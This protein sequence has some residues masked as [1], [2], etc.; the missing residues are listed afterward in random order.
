MRKSLLILIFIFI[1][2]L[3]IFSQKEI[4]LKEAKDFSFELLKSQ[5]QGFQAVQKTGH[6]NITPE[7]TKSGTFS[8]IRTNKLMK[9]F[10]KGYPDLP[11]VSK[12]IEIPVGADIN[13]KVISYDLEI[14]NLNKRGIKNKLAPAQP[15]QEKSGGQK[16]D[17]FYINQKIYNTNEFIGEELVKVEDRGIMRNKRF[18]RLQISPL[19]YNPVANKLKVYNNIKIDVQFKNSDEKKADQLNKQYTSPYFENIHKKAVNYQDNKEKEVIDNSPITYVIISDPMFKTQLQ[20]FIK[21]KERKGFNVITAYTDEIG[22]TTS[23]IKSYL[24]D[25]YY[26]PDPTPPSFV[27]FVGDVDQVPAWEG[28]A[29]NHVTD[30]YYCEYT[31]DTLPDVYYGRFSAQSEAQLQTQIDKTLEYEKYEMAHPEYLSEALLVAGNDKEWEDIYGNGAMWYAD[32]Y[33]FNSNNDI[34]SHLFLQD[35]PNGNAAVHDSIIKNINAGV[36]YANYTAHCSSS[37]WAEPSF[38]N[39]DIST[40]TNEGKYGLWVGNCC[41]SLKFDD[42]ECFGEAALRAENKGA[43]GYIGGSN[44]TYWY[45]DYWWGVGNIASPVEQPSYNETG[46]GMYDGMFHT[47][48]NE[49]DDPS[50]WYTTQA[51]AITCGNLAVDASTSNKKEYY[52]EI[53]HLMGD[54][55]LMPYLGPPESISISI[56]PSELLIGTDSLTINTA[57]YAYVALSFQGNLLDA[58]QTGENGEATLSFNP[59]Q[60][61]GKVSLV[62]TAQNKQLYTDSIPIGRPATPYIVPDSYSITDTSGN[63]N[64]SIDFGEIISL[65]VT[66]KNLSDSAK[67]ISISDSLSEKDSYIS[68]IDSTQEYGN[69]EASGDSLIKGAFSFRVSDSVA[70][71]H[72]A[73]F[74]M[75]ISGKDTSGLEY[76]WQSIFNITINAPKLEIENLA[77]DDKSTGDGDS[78][79]DPGEKA[80]LLVTVQNT[81]SSKIY[82]IKGNLKSQ[83]SDITI[84]QGVDSSDNLSANSEVTFIF[85]VQAS[86]STFVGSKVNLQIEVSGGTNG[87]YKAS[88]TQQL[89]IGN[90]ATCLINEDDTVNTCGAYF[91]DSGADT[92]DYSNSES[93]TITFY[94]GISGKYIQAIFK[95]FNVEANNYE[96]GCY[97]KLYI[98]DGPDTDAELIGT[99]CNNNPPDTIIANN[100]TGALTFQF[101]SDGSLTKSGWKT[102]ITCIEKNKVTFSVNDGKNPLE[103][104][105]I[106]CDGYDLSTNN[107]GQASLFL[108]NDSYKYT[109]SKPGYTKITDTIKVNSDTTIHVNLT[110][111]IYNVEFDVY[112]SGDT[113]NFIEGKV[114]FNDTT[115]N[116]INGTCL[117]QNIDS[118]EYI[119]YQVDARGY[120]SITDSIIVTKDTTIDIGLK[121]KRFDV[122]IYTESESGNALSGVNVKVEDFKEK[123]D[124]GGY[125]SFIGMPGGKRTCYAE[126]DGY[127]NS[128]KEIFIYKDSTYKIVLSTLTDLDEETD[129]T[130]KIYPNPAA[131]IL[132]I[133]KTIKKPIHY[134]IIDL[135]GKTLQTGMLSSPLNKIKVSSWQPGIYFIRFNSK[136]LEEQYKLM[137]E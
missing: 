24:E 124:T 22:N 2:I 55:S 98:Y 39:S 73:E 81:G 67:A 110:P 94:P 93:D 31:G 18:G 29:G 117:F 60:D 135:T 16:H 91:Y 54:P 69:I 32:N 53:Y 61:T 101:S 95:E 105:D 120:F 65:D 17:K 102:E 23:E 78:I 116:A 77:I 44:N 137:I 46:R 58:K 115:K 74:L 84:N 72:Q 38:A 1:S 119:S 26:N 8:E 12:L 79:L 127:S 96:G 47:K 82:D 6:L 50:E 107:E 134:K 51:Q 125:V 71:Q 20:P 9:T 85:K 133:E 7:K 123:T 11:V 27:L 99:F 37:G 89:V 45:E 92:S 10:R 3:Q 35:P 4:R 48:A 41:L 56:T 68:L 132:F 128:E 136:Y 64:G 33:Y 63:N 108:D 30:F 131:D 43:I 80:D 57:S 62:V 100:Q 122:V 121:P 15:S 104:A 59:I 103:D 19:K 129:E 111:T 126:K 113:T 42:N 14:I 13:V 76:N 112:E 70:D 21:W 130:F 66:L 88:S 49:A 34:N 5:K 87:Q 109:A 106:N 90:M 25:L 114:T 97:D 75:D 52:W 86:E 40:L 36:S 118:P 83:T 28:N